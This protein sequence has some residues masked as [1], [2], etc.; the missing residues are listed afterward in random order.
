MNIEAN[1][2]HESLPESPGMAPAALSA[3]RPMYWSIRRE[4]WENRSIYIAPLAVATVFLVGF[5]VSLSGLPQRMRFSIAFHAANQRTPIEVPYDVAEGMIMGAALMVQIFYCLDALH[6]ERR[7]RSILFWKSVPVSDLTT[8]LSK[9][10]IPVIVLAVS[11][12]ITVA[13][14]LIALLLSSAVLAGSGMSAGP[15]WM[16]VRLFE[17]S[18]GL[19]YHLTTVH[20]LWYAPIY[21]WLLLISVW[22]RRV[23]LLWAVLPPFAI[24]LVEKVAFNTS[25]F[26]G[27]I[28]YRFSGPEPFTFS[29][30]WNGPMSMQ[31]HSGGF[32]TTPG[33]WL[34]LVAAAA[35]LA[36]AVRMRRNRGPI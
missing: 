4:L 32:F 10:S 17:R 20:T 6:G 31:P 18:W 36:A 8:V 30:P 11:F 13:T 5:L 27:W 34:G 25:H 23:P 9:A 33:L 12:A 15:L 29:Q 22:A 14:Q 1:V 21:A 19:F 28:I 2:V 16:Q 26:A 7:D 35:F 3:T 24:G